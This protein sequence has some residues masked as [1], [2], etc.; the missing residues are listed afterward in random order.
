MS[1]PVAVVAFGGNA[2]IRASENGTLEEQIH[3]A[4]RAV[5]PLARVLERGFRLLIVHGNGPQAGIEMIRVEESI[6]KVPPV[7]LDMCVASTQGSMAFLLQCALGNE[8]RRTGIPVRVATVVTQ[9]IVDAKDQAFEK[10]TKPVGPF[11]TEYRAR[12]LRRKQGWN[13]VEDSGRGWR[14]VVSSPHPEE[15][16]E[17]SAVQSLLEENHIVIAGG[18]GGIPVVR[19]PDGALQGV[20]A[21]IDKDYTASL[22]ARRVQAHLFVILTAVDRIFIN[23]GQS[24]ERPLRKLT[25]VEAR[26]FLDEGQ[27]PEGSMG[28]K[29]RAAVEFLEGGGREVVVTNEETM[30]AALEGRGGT[31]ILHEGMAE[32][33]G[34]QQVLFW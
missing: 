10:P 18:G 2:L 3:N 5:R 13:M 12:Q 1:N 32:D 15:I 34:G 22:L 9:V 33:W 26:R 27:F 28:P 31:T 4:E 20:E 11:F 17:V 7:T 24:D 21:V 8:C 29:V 23:F 19:R 30:E 14:K 25:P 16:V 6:T